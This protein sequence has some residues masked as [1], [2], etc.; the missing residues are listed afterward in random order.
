MLRR[1]T[2]AIKTFSNILFYIARTKQYH[3]RSYQYDQIIKKNEQMYALLAVAASLSPQQA[4]DENLVSTLRDKYADRMSRMQSNNVDLQV[5]EELFSFACPKFITPAPPN[6]DN[7]P[8]NYNP[9]EAYRLQLRLFSAE[10][11]QQKV[12]PTIRSYLK[13]YTTI[14]IPKLAALAE[15]DDPTFREHLQ[16]LKH[17]T[18]AMSWTGG[19][20]LTG[21]WA[22]AA[23]VDFYVDGEV[24]HVADSSLVRK[25]SDY[26]VKQ[27]NKL[28]EIISTLK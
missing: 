12:L 3:T 24:A 20:P 18:Q 22:S 7:L 6:Y 8:A 13:L 27:I 25:H 4:L 26:F 16:C 14:G 9:Q 15:A 5:Y 17:K 21:S 23:E 28:E 19:G 11:S 2:D 1:Y 10:V